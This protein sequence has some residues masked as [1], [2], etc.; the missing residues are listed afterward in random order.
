MDNCFN[1]SIRAHQ[2]FITILNDSLGQVKTYVGSD[3]KLHFVDAS[4][5]DTV[6][7]FS[8]EFV[9]KRF[10]LHSASHQADG[11]TEESYLQIENK[12]WTHLTFDRI[13]GN[14]VYYHAYETDANGNQ[15]TISSSG[16]ILLNS[17]VSKAV[18]NLTPN[19]TFTFKFYNT[20]PR[21]YGT[22]GVVENL[23][24]Y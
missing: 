7:P 23:R 2:I 17:T 8:N 1:I 21:Y 20:Y 14:A 16:D 5:A 3:G 18:W 13:Y 4:G 19:T 6:L 22:E 15:R 9:V 12:N 24:F 11:T 10:S